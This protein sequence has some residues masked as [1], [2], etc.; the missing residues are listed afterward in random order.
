[1]AYAQ[2]NQYK[3]ALDPRQKRGIES[4]IAL[5]SIKWSFGIECSQ[6]VNT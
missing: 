3:K 6:N 5:K 2:I 1:M 4:L